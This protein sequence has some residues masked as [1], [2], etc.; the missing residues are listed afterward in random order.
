MDRPLDTQLSQRRGRSRWITVIALVA[1][2][3]V[4]FWGLRTIL[5]PSASAA[6][7]RFATV[8]RGPIENAVTAS[9]V[10]TPSFEQQVNAPIATEI[11]EVLKRSG[12]RVEAGD[13]ILRL[14]Q[15]FIQLDVESRKS[16][17]DLKQNQ[18]GLLQLEL[19]RDLKE[20]EYD[21]SIKGLEVASAEAKLSDARR[22]E[23]IGGA[24]AEEVEQAEV[25]LQILQLEK[26]KLENELAYRRASLAGR[27]LEVEL[28]AKIEEK[29]LREIQRKMG[30]TEVRAPGPGVITWINESIGE[31]VG[32]GKP[33]V[34]L[35]DLRSFHIEASCSDR[36]ADR[37]KLGQPVRVR[38]NSRDLRGEVSSILPSVENNT[39]A[40]LVNLADPSDAQLRPNMRLDVYVITDRKEDALRVQRGPAFNGARRQ[41]LFV[42]RGDQAVKTD[43]QVGLSNG[44]FVEIQSDNVA[45]GDRIVISNTEDYEHLG[46]LKL[47]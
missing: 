39:L 28:E 44:D 21:D 5:A 19:D 31:Q 25:K 35:A 32:E 23:K 3:A 34:R 8:E 30:L 14:D 16:Q 12:D 11:Q 6:D 7:L 1:G 37:V 10:V 15:E 22:L 42:V 38:I 45:P 4:V 33:L 24:T 20:L 36:Y 29:E 18:V 26:K 41:G 9:G 47:K 46:T 13:L 2:A 17:L 43:V 40:F 27:R